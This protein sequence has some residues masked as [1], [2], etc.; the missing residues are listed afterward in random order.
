[1]ARHANLPFHF[2]VNVDNKFLGA[3]MPSGTTSAIWH[4]VYC[5]PDQIL[6]CHVLLESGANWS[7][8]PIQALSTKENFDIPEDLLM[9]WAAMGDDLEVF[10]SKYLEGLKCETI[11][12]LTTKARHTGIIVD[13]ADG[14]SRYPQE[15]KPLNL[16]ELES[17]QFALF[18]NNY[19]VYEDS[20]FVT[21]NGKENLKYYKRGDKVY[22]GK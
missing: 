15:H 5:R 18:P 8:L 7:G 22:W 10:H 11:K 17:G 14:F 21:E 6:M 2:Y 4:S 16:L 9:P 20:H 3:K 1:M 12:K 13:W 19:I